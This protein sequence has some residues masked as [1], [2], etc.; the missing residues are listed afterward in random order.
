MNIFLKKFS[1]YT[2][3]SR[4]RQFLNL[5]RGAFWSVLGNVFYQGLNFIT[6][7]IIARYLGKTAFG[8]FG[9]INNTF[10]MF[11]E[12]SGIGLGLTATKYIAEF[13]Y[14][15]KEN[16]GKIIGLTLTFTFILGLIFSLIV[17]NFPEF[18]SDKILNAPHLKYLLKISSSLILINALIGVLNGIFSGFEAFKE[19]SLINASRGVLNLIFMITGV[20]TF[21]TVGL[22]IGYLFV[23]V[24]TLLLSVILLN[25]I[26]KRENLTIFFFNFFKLFTTVFKFSFPAFLS[27]VVVVISMWLANIIIVNLP[28]GYSELGQLNAALQFRGILMFLPAII[29]QVL[30]P[31]MVN[32]LMHQADEK[33]N[34]LLLYAQ[35]LTVFL[36]LPIGCI[37]IFLSD[38]IPYIYGE[39]F[40]GSGPLFIGIVWSVMI[41]SLG[42]CI[43]TYIQAKGKMWI[44]FAINFS[45][46]LMLVVITWLTS[47]FIGSKSIAFGSAIS[48]FVATIW[49]F[50]YLSPEL[51][52]KMS[53]RIYISL[54]FSFILVGF[55]LLLSPL[56]KLILLMPFSLLTLYLSINFFIDSKVKL[57]LSRSFS[58]VLKKFKLNFSLINLLN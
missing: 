24:I 12:F 48:Y 16:T 54:F 53:K 39:S 4:N 23:S 50:H 35:S 34:S 7:I 11:G 2:S 41:M 38:F 29:L 18:I 10:L 32:S 6:F 45:Y 17:Y 57:R 56:L 52:S 3:F 20:Y 14:N 13:R 19:I 51:P 31:V 28:N 46:S 40:I 22:L 25:N 21:H 27:S 1:F 15:D 5:F 55:S 8:E 44:G 58:L 37:L 49:L 9:I 42:M 47:P 36:V 30:L 43:G 26:K 33:D